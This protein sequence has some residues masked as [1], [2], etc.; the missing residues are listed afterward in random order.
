MP[1]TKAKGFYKPFVHPEAFGYYKRQSQLHWIIDE[2]KL[3]EDIKDYHTKLQSIER[4][5]NGGK[6]ARAFLSQLFRFFTQGDC[7]VGQAYMNIFIPFFENEEI[8]MM[9]STFC[10]MESIHAEAYA[11]LLD[12]V[13]MDE[14]EYK[15]FK[16][17]EQ[18]AAKHDYTLQFR[19]NN[20]AEMVKAIAVFSAFT[21]GM[22]LF[23]S[24]AMLLNFP[25]FGVMNGMGQV[26]SASIKDETCHTEGMVWL[27]R[28][29]IKEHS[30]VW[31]DSLR[32]EIYEIAR[33]MV[34]LE[35]KFI[36]MA[37]DACNDNIKGITRQELKQYIRYI[38][39]RRLLELGMKANF[40]IEENPLPWIAE[41][42][43]LFGHSNFFETTEMSYTKGG[44][45]GSWSDVWNV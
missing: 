29:F 34:D 2:I 43:N 4:N 9:L 24:F 8:R 5:P 33:Q 1:V 11:A 20:H 7:D 19:G 41:Q 42:L 31:T 38:C 22:Q 30:R 18:M 35:D 17:Y 37:F 36:D 45:T 27:A 28:E 32:G 13:G 12:A 39:D 44:L 23:S 16:E 15:A 40:G 14:I 25:R 26:V 10:Q 6:D 3:H 21:E